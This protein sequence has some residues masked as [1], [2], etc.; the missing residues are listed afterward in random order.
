MATVETNHP[1]TT[2]DDVR[3]EQRTPM[4]WVA[5]DGWDDVIAAVENDGVAFAAID[6]DGARI[7]RF[8][9]LGTA[10]HEAES[11]ARSGA[12]ARTGVRGV[13]SMRIPLGLGVAC[14]VAAAGGASVMAW[15]LGSGAI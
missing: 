9:D 12:P 5:L 4:R 1:A 11:A 3:W 2:T 15:L 13:L 14:V 7:G 10:V 6:A 8:A